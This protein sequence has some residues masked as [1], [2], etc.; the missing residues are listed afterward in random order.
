MRL[1]WIAFGLLAA[2]A[3]V[4]ADARADVHVGVGIRVGDGYHRGGGDAWQHG[5]SRGAHEGYREGEKDAR[6]RDRFHF[7]D[8]G[9]YRDSDRGYKKWMGPRHVYERAYRAGYQ[10]GYGRGY[11]QFARYDRDRYGDR[12]YPY[13]R[14][15][16]GDGRYGE[17]DDRDWHDR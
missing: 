5:Y 7:R 1:E 6:H 10:E 12:R 15:P 9:S 3:V 11:R 17:R 16:Y 2:S 4:A 13:G 14:Y 8:E